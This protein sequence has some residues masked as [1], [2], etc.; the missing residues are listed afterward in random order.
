LLPLTSLFFLSVLLTI[1]GAGRARAEFV[2]AGDVP[3]AGAKPAL[4]PAGTLSALVIFAKFQG[5]VPSEE[6]APAWAADLFNRSR[7]GSFAHFYDEMSRGKLRVD[8]QVLPRRYSSRQPAAA[9]LAET[10]G[11]LGRF[12][13][14]NLE[15]LEQAD[16]DVDMGRFDNDG[17]DGEPNSGDDDGYVD[18]AFINLLT[19]PRDFFVGP[20]T[21]FASLGLDTDFISDDPA[22]GGG[23]IRVRSRFTGFGGTT[24]RGHV[25]SVT[26]ATMCHEFGHVLGL[27]DLFDQSAV[28][29]GE[30]LDPEEDSAGIGKWGLMGLGT[31]GWGLEDGPNAFSAWS[32]ARLGWVEVVEVTES[33]QDLVV[34]DV[35]RS[36][37]VYRIPLTR[38]EYFLL[39]NRQASGSYYNRNLPRGGLLIWHV[40]ERA[41]ND[42]ERHKQVDLVC[43]DG[44]Y[45]DRGFP[46]TQPAPAV[47][48]DNLDFWAKDGAYA[49]AHN[50][51]QGDATDP[52]DGVRFTRFAYDTNPPLSAHAGFARNLPLGIAVDNIR[53]DGERMIVDVLLRQPLEGHVAADT[54][55][56]VAVEVDG[57]VVVEPGATLTVKA[58]TSVRFGP[59]DSRRSGFDPNRSELLVFGELVLQGTSEA[60]VRLVSAA[61]LP[62]SRDWAGVFLLDGQDLDLNRTSIQHAMHGLVRFFLPPGQTRWEGLVNVPMD[63]VVPADAELVMAPGTVVQFGLDAS[64]RGISPQFTELIVEGRLTVQGNALQPTRLTSD[65]REED[66]IWY[67]VRLRPGAQVDARFVQVDQAGFGFSGEVSAASR[68]HIADGRIRDMA[69]GGLRLTL[70]GRA[71]VDRTLFTRNAGQAIRVEGSGRLVLRQANVAENGQEGIFLGNASLEVIASLIVSSGLLE[72]EDPRSGLRAVGGRGQEIAMRDSRIASNSLHGLELDEW[73]GTLELR[74]TEIVANRRDGLRARGLERVVLEDVE[75]SRNLR[76]GAIIARSPVEIRNAS[77][78]AN[79]GTALTL[80]EETSGSIEASEFRGGP[81]LELRDLETL[82]VRGSRFENLLVALSLQNAAPSIEN[83]YFVDNRTAIQV[84]GPRVPIAIRRNVFLNNRTAIENLSA[85]TLQAQENYWGTA[86]SAAI[87]AAIEGAVAWTPFLLEKPDTTVMEEEEEDTSSGGMPAQFALH[88]AYP[89]PFNGLVTIAF[90][91]PRPARTELVVYDVLGHPVRRILE[92]VLEPGF[93]RQAWNGRDVRGRE[94]ASGVYFYR[95]RAGKFA[96]TGRVTL[97][98]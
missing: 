9:Y 5:E 63:L 74:D 24:Q 40:D 49:A 1:L 42:E 54:V 56:S 64:R 25:F 93:Y 33:V 39:E 31:L 19:V 96:K 77:F 89:N 51:N 71:E 12:G 15:I 35:V 75:V 60:P 76:G 7:P 69:G 16:S 78:A 73:E 20:A 65:P 14:F 34:E 61:G 38:D 8:G 87:A 18:I 70:N 30:T 72:S 48:R 3:L 66:A 97:L 81:G 80:E 84:R 86:D 41:D 28:T 62:R 46:G 88:P 68:L 17:P 52:F 13:Q 90:D 11:T 22:A 82:S 10:P 6:W 94:L 83:N 27:P 59:G 92:A 29:A 79:I 26:A 44:L 45:A 50:G 2:C 23:G 47:G 36:G 58:G 53:A 91:I 95:L 57:D 67:G 21:G 4:E 85:L 55:W 32:L 43:A 37:R 98:R